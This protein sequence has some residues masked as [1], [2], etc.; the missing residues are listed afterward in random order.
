M[1]PLG[2]A[3]FSQYR[4]IFGEPGT[5][6]F[7]AAGFLARLPMSMIGI[8]IVVMLSE[9][10]D[11]YGVAGA[12]AATYACATALLGP[13]VARAIDRKGQR[14]VA[15]PALLLSTTALVLL[16]VLSDSAFPAWPLFVCAFTAGLM[17]SIGSLVRARWA[18]VLTD[19]E[20]LQTAYS[21][22][23]VADEVVYIV[24]PLLA[25]TLASSFFPG[26][27]V[28]AA[29]G[30][31]LLGTLAF[32]AQRS[33][34]PAVRKRRGNTRSALRIPALTVLVAVL[35][36]VGAIFGSFEVAVVGFAEAQGS[37][38]AA[39]YVL[40]V[41]AAGG[42]LAGLL[43]GAVAWDRP[44]DRRFLVC[45]CAMP[46]LLVPLPLS[47]SLGVLTAAMF[48][49]GL[50]TA[51]VLITSMTLVEHLVPDAS[52]TEGLTWATSGLNMGLAFGVAVGGW[53][54]DQS[55]ARA[56]LLVPPASAVLAGIIA[57]IGRKRLRTPVAH[58]A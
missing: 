55:G 42:C 41:N 22:E 16:L 10:R 28:L 33:T 46:V 26:A 30:L 25:V 51:P 50:A 53:T 21:F 18:D 31:A 1:N 19:G 48:V 4:Q 3:V 7:S 32:L 39:S 57:V 5:R 52:L 35:V 14:A 17:P 27:G 34:E 49:A 23:S 2:G 47:S 58:T 24:G 8:G 20:A 9:T 15:L 29:G 56:A 40:A 11:S 43:F 44:L 13:L 12:V 37:R 54:V 36:A 38:G 6:G 45:V